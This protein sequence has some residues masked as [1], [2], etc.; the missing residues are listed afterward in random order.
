MLEEPVCKFLHTLQKIA[1]GERAVKTP[2]MLHCD[3]ARRGNDFNAATRAKTIS[4]E[5]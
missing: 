4:L 5:P 2:L 1:E 3:Q